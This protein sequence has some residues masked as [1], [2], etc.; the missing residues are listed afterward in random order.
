MK[1]E[2]NRRQ[3]VTLL[4]GV[5]GVGAVTLVAHADQLG[6]TKDPA[7]ALQK[8]PW[9]YKPLDADKVAQRGFEA[10][11]KGECMYGAFDAIV[12]PVAEQLGSPYTTFPF[13]MFK[14]GGGGIKGW[15]TVCGA[16]NGSAAAIQLLSPEPDVLVN[17]LFAWYEHEQL[18][19]VHPKGAK[20]PEVRSKAGEPL[21]HASIA[22]WTKAS[23]KQA[24]SPER[25]ERCACLVASVAKQTVFLLNQQVAK[26][27]IVFALPTATEGCMS[28]HEKGGAVENIRTKMDCGGCHAPLMGKHP[29][30][31]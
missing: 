13:A 2:M 25:S 1:K 31:S 28:C 16:L 8:I 3:L 27:P 12:G 24:Y 10:F 15:G 14:Y 19:D 6:G 26:K 11:Y 22:H 4:T 23:G 7:G 9:P 5:A 20:F 18:P 17:T 30:Q 21:C 29:S